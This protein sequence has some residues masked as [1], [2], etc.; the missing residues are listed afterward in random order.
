MSEIHHCRKRMQVFYGKDPPYYLGWG[1]AGVLTL[2]REDDSPSM[3]LLGGY[4]NFCY[5]G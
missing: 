3:S 2:Y 5:K 4:P 1:R